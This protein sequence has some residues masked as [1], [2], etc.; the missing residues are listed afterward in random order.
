MVLYKFLA[1]NRFHQDPHFVGW[2]QRQDILPPTPE[3]LEK[4]YL[5]HDAF[6]E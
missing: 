3:E 6:M 5:D 2:L 1:E 4:L